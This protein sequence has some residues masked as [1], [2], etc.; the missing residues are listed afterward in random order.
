MPSSEDQLTLSTTS[1]FRL[2]GTIVADGSRGIG[3]VGFYFD[4]NTGKTQ[5]MKLAFA[6]SYATSATDY[7]D[8]QREPTHVPDGAWRV[9]SRSWSAGARPPCVVDGKVRAAVLL[10]PSVT[11]TAAPSSPTLRFTNLRVGSA[12]AG[13]GC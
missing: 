12:P 3:T 4:D 11:V 9:R 13:S 10:P 7:N 8:F 5:Q 1:C 6:G 2:D